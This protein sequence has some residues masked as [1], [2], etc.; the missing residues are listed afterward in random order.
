[1]ALDELQHA[2]LYAFAEHV[3]VMDGLSDLREILSN[4]SM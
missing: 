3:R 1:V 4:L 2:L